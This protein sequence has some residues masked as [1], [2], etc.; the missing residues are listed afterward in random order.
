MANK[1]PS[2]HARTAAHEQALIE[3]RPCTAWTC[4]GE[5]KIVVKAKGW[6]SVWQC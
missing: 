3:A 4:K 2:N 6:K 5:M 1:T